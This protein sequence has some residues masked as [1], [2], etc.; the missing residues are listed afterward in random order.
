MSADDNGGNAPRPWALEGDPPEPQTVD[1]TTTD[2]EPEETGLPT[3]TGTDP[4]GRAIGPAEDHKEPKLDSEGRTA[5][6]AG[7]GVDTGTGTP[8]QP[9]SAEDDTTEDDA[10]GGNRDE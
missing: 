6:E 7:T 3:H 5:A 4:Y 2:D 1:P 8:A 10:K 9:G